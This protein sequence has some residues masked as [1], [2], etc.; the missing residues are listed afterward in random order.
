VSRVRAAVI[1]L[2]VLLAVYVGTYFALLDTTNKAS[3]YFGPKYKTD[4]PTAR[5]MFAPF[6]VARL[7]SPAPLL[8]RPR[9]H[10]AVLTA[11]PAGPP[12]D[13]RGMGQE[14]DDYSDPDPRLLGTLSPTKLAL[15]VCVAA[16]LTGLAGW[17]LYRIVLAHP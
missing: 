5:A 15:L 14:H 7:Q 4:S 12:R 16:G 11:C 10:H 2:A 9:T 17:F 13:T 6:G 3:P 8:A 1:V